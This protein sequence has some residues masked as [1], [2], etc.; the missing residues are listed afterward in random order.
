[1]SLRQI[2]I[3]VAGLA[4]LLVADSFGQSLGDVAKQQKQAKITK[5]ASTSKKVI[6]NEDMPDHPDTAASSSDST[7][8]QDS[9]IAPASNDRHSAAQ[10]KAVIVQQ[11]NTIAEMQRNVD[12]L[13]N[14]IHF[15]EANRY[16]NGVQYNQHQMQKLQELDQAQKQLDEQ[17]KRLEE[18]QE[19]A[20]KAGLGSAVYDP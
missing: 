1:M 5:T 19:G 2:A 8:H 3:L 15:V 14:S 20:R 12:Q 11:K 17:K 7:P 16:S 18:M 13:K 9:Y 10:W 6:T 4:T